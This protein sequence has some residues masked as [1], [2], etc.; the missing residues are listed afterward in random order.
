[1]IGRI[2]LS[3]VRPGD[4]LVFKGKGQP[5]GV[6]SWLIKRFKE[7]NWD[8]Y[9]WHLAP[10][11][12]VQHE[13]YLQIVYIDA[14]FPRLKLSALKPE[15]QVRCYRVLEKPPTKVKIQLVINRYV[16]CFYDPIV[17]L[18]TLLSVFLRPRFNFF[19]PRIINRLYSCWEG[20]FEALD[21][22]GCDISWC[23]SYPWLTDFLRFVGEIND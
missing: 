21:E 13:P 17:Y 4:V 9:G 14:Q 15:A 1:M 12:K 7:P 22:W 18:W 19:V 11:V 10:I 8:K 6:L 5:Y 3:E 23:Y 16:G 2:S 20:T